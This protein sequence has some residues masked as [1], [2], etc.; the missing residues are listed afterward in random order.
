MTIRHKHTVVIR[1]VVVSEGESHIKLIKLDWSYV[2]NSQSQNSCIG[3]Q[4]G[5]KALLAAQPELKGLGSR[6]VLIIV[7]L[8]HKHRF[9][10]RTSIA[11]SCSVTRL[12]WFCR[13][14]SPPR[15]NNASKAPI[16]PDSSPVT[17]ENIQ[18]LSRSHNYELGIGTSI[19]IGFW[20]LKE[21]DQ[22]VCFAQKLPG[23]HM[24]GCSCSTQVIIR[25]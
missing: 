1:F 4:S 6:Q 20:P 22:S 14:S 18:R 25:A 21:S 3:I 10:L 13:S 24:Q 23:K 5:P 15:L 17:D 16:E 9:S 8:P 11:L 7:N 19:W 12:P 2:P